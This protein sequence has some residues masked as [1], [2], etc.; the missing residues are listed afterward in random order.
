MF[1][2]QGVKKRTKRRTEQ[3]SYIKK[4]EEKKERKGR[5]KVYS[6]FEF[7]NLYVPTLERK[8][9]GNLSETFEMN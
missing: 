6:R 9:K 7:Q 5:D 2:E 3:R 8:V 4:N 1:Y